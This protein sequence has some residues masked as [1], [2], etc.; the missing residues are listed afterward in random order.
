MSE[1]EPIDIEDIDLEEM[2][3]LENLVDM[4]YPKIQTDDPEALLDRFTHTNPSMAFFKRPTIRQVV[5]SRDSSPLLAQFRTSFFPDLD[6]AEIERQIF[7]AMSQG[8]NALN[9]LFGIHLYDLGF[10][11]LVDPLPDSFNLVDFLSLGRE[12]YLAAKNRGDGSVD[13][14]FLLSAYE[15]AR[16]Y[17]L[18]YRILMINGEPRVLASVRNFQSH[19]AWFK[20]LFGFW[21]M[22]QEDEMY[23]PSSWMTNAGV[24][25]YGDTEPMRSRVKV[26]NSDGSVKYDSLLMKL[27][28]REDFFEGID[29]FTGVEFV[30]QDNDSRKKL[31][32]YLKSK[33]KSGEKFVGY[34]DRTRHSVDNPTSS[35]RF[36]NISFGLYIPTRLDLPG[37][38]SDRV[39][40]ERN[41]VENQILT[42]KEAR[43]SREDPS[44][45]HTNYKGKQFRRVFPA[46]FPRGIYE[47]LIREHYSQT[48]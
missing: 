22:Q 9:S 8:I 45:D 31:I 38:F 48:A 11:F 37:L 2:Y 6:D 19:R 36:S 46:W 17:D 39:S 47:P 3:Q 44:V 18:G 34:K 35:S 14:D 10:D 33:G 25:V 29:D 40:Y 27:C 30:V 23:F 24:R 15:K 4:L 32:H 42:L 43:V 16:A 26:L 1:A 20:N 41:L 12:E 7:L 28:L 13:N 5:E 21:D